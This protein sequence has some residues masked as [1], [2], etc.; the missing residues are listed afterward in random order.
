MKVGVTAKIHRPEF[1]ATLTEVLDWLKQREWETIVEEGVARAFNLRGVKTASQDDLPDL[2][3]FIVVFGGDGTMLAVARSIRGRKAPILGV[4][5]GGLGFMT[6]VTMGELYP[7]LERLLAGEYTVDRRSMLKVEVSHRRGEVETH[8]AFNDCVINKAA[9]ARIIR[10]D[11][12]V[13]EDFI[14]T[15]PADGL[16]IAT[17]TG[18]TAY[19]LSAGG[20]VV[21]PTLDAMVL[22]PICPHT[23]TNR[24]IV[25]PASSTIRVVVKAGEEVMLTVD[26]QIGVALSPGDEIRC[27]RSPYEVELIQ[28]VNRGFFDILREKLKWG[29]R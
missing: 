7:A 29:G 5:Q 18:S 12:F 21:Y 20:P 13:E 1:A 28:P 23:L 2:V 14:A 6:E 25:V 9:L 17:P 11:A 26:G 10:I 24:P 8:H 19:S 3:D 22:T 27:T 4:N 16:I 15:F